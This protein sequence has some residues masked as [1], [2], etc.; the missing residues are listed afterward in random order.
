VKQSRIHLDIARR[1]V[2]TLANGESIIL[3]NAAV[4]VLKP[5]LKD[6]ITRAT[7]KVHKLPEDW[8]TNE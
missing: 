2:D 5:L 8:F 1:I 7:L 6:H 3:Q 4:K